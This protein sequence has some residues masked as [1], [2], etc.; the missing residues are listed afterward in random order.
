MGVGGWEVEQPRGMRSPLS[1]LSIPC[2]AKF[3]KLSHHGL[4]TDVRAAP[5]TAASPWIPVCVYQ[6]ATKITFP[7]ELR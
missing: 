3:Y 7:W 6:R 1:Q 2:R 5:L 4:V